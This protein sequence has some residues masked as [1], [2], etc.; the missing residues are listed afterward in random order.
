MTGGT[1]SLDMFRRFVRRRRRELDDGRRTAIVPKLRRG[2]AID[3]PEDAELAL[4]AVAPS[5][6]SAPPTAR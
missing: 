1:G 4:R 2:E 5:A 3:D 6:I